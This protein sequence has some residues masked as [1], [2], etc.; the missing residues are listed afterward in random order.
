[1]EH[2]GKVEPGGQAWG[3]S[4]FPG[5]GEGFMAPLAG[6]I[7]IAK[8]P[9]GQAQPGQTYHPSVMPVEEGM[10]AVLGRIIERQSLFEVGSGLDELSKTEQGLPRRPVGF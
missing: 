1:M 8:H 10:G 7:W 9:Q 5:E 3:M 6:L 4:Q 2:A